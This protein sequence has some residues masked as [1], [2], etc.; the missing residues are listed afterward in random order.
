VIGVL[1]GLAWAEAVLVGHSYGGL[2]TL[3]VAA[4]HPDRCSGVLLVDSIG[5]VGD[6]GLASF[7]AE[8]M[9]RLPETALAR[10]AELDGLP[11]TPARLDESLRLLWP[12]YFADPAN[13]P[14][15]LSVPQSPEA[16]AA[17]MP[18]AIGALPALADTLPRLRM[19]L[20]AVVGAASPIPRSASEDVVARVPGAWLVEVP[21]AGH[22]PW[23]ERRGC[24]DAALSRFRTHL[25]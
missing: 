20:G 25:G 18:A 7:E 2:L 21:G 13:A 16:F 24:V 23:M 11:P 17:L 4:R 14:E 19:P 3:L 6:G 22:F 8:L 10:V 9:S 1:D 15:Y 12:A 5:A